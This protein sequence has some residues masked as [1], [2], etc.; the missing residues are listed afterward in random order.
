MTLLL[1]LAAVL[2]VG[3]A[4]ASAYAI[5]LNRRRHLQDT[6]PELVRRENDHMRR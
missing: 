1:T 3:F 2:I 5:V 6:R 4:I